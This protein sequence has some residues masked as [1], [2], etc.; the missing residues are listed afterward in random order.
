[1]DFHA[2]AACQVEGIYA[3]FP[4]RSGDIEPIRIEAVETWMSV[5]AKALGLEYAADKFAVEMDYPRRWPIPG[6]NHFED[7]CWEF[8]RIPYLM[9]EVP[10]SRV[11]ETILTRERFREAGSRVAEA[12][13][14]QIESL[15]DL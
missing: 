14:E 4:A 15:Y 3:Y 1:M 13:S 2:P 9:L 7:F 6:S 12:I 11:G 8:F 5:A 10:Y